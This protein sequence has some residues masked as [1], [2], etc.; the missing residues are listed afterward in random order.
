MNAPPPT[1]P[2]AAGTLVIGLSGGIGSGKSA[3]ARLLAG[4][5]GEVIDADRLAREALGSER[6]RGLVRE[7]FGGGVFDATGAIDRDALAR[8]VFTDP[9]QRRALEGWIHPQ[10]R[11]TMARRLSEGRARGVPRIVLDVPLLFENDTEH[12]LV[13]ECDRLVFVDADAGIREQRVLRDRGWAPGELARRE[14]CQAPLDQKRARSDHVIRNDAD[15][16]QLASAVRRLS[17]ELEARRPT[18]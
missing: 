10:V 3:V 5:D 1:P 14:S 12:H 6:V 13:G 4:P 8:V 9:E 16:D 15:L 11:V 7:R 2:S 18:P 17:E